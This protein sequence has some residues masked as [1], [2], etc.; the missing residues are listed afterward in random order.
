[1]SRVRRNEFFVVMI[2]LISVFIYIPYFFEVPQVMTNLENWFMDT[3]V[4]IAAFAVWVGFITS[5]RREVVRIQRRRKGWYYAVIILVLSW[6][7]VIIGLG[8][9]KTNVIFEFLQYAFVLPGDSTIYAILVFYL[10]SSGARAF[11]V[12]SLESALLTFGALFV[13]LKQAPL[14]EVLAPWAGPVAIYLQDTIAMAATRVF[15]VSMAVG[16][17]VLAIRLML[18]QEMALVGLVRRIAKRDED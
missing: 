9:S 6:L 3:I 8:V 16:S 1:M 17:V 15:N 7:M 18:G 4:I 2:V 12:N 11:R 10:T 13:L 14:G 5:T